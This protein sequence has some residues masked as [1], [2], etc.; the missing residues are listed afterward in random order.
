MIFLGVNNES[1][2][3]RFIR[4]LWPLTQHAIASS[5]MLNAPHEVGRS[6]APP[7]RQWDAVCYNLVV[8]MTLLFCLILVSSFK[9]DLN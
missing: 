1:T 7:S 3:P 5:S 2:I 4:Q 6:H 9:F 8:G